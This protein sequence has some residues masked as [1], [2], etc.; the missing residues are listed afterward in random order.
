MEKVLWV[1]NNVHYPYRKQKNVVLPNP[2]S[3]PDI[4]R[5]LELFEWHI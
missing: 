5:N 1:S 4:Q 3:H 2:L